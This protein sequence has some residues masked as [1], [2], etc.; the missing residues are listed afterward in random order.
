MWGALSDERTGLSFVRV[1]VSSKLEALSAV[2]QTGMT[3]NEKG[4]K[5]QGK[6][7]WKARYRLAEK[8]ITSETHMLV[9]DFHKAF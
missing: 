3:S 6:P 9:T 4:L 7:T 5:K 8:D 2:L 1:A